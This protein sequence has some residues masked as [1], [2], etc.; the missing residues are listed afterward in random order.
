MPLVKSI[1]ELKIQLALKKLSAGQLSLEESQ[2]ELAKE[3]ASAID[4]YIKSATIIVP[5]G[6]LVTGASPAGPVTGATT[7]PIT[8]TIT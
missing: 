7:V 3:L 5:A 6:Q 4:E 1:L 2:K 8:A